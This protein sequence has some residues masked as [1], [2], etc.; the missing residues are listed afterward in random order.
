[1]Q[2]P[3]ILSQSQ[4][5]RGCP[6]RRQELNLV[7]RLGDNREETLLCLNHPLVDTT[8][9]VAERDIR[10]LKFKQKI[11]GSFRTDDGARDFAILR[12]V[13][14]TARKHGWNALDTLGTPADVLIEQLTHGE[15]VQDT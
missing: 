1:M 14:E 7:L 5:G 4:K 13:L 10:S 15:L 9:N 6:K 8:N 11:S 3:Q 12:S 2:L